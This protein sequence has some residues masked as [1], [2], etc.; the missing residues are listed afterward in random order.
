MAKQRF[1]QAVKKLYR[2]I[3]PGFVT[4][5]S[6][7]DPSGIATYSQTG[8]QFGYTQLWFAI[9]SMPF[10]IA[11]QEMCGR[12]GMVTGKGIAGLMRKHYS[13]PLLWSM[14]SLLFLANVINLGA[15]LGA[16]AAAVQLIWPVNFDLILIVI[17][18]ITLLLLV[19]VPYKIY[20]NILKYLTLSLFA[21]VG[22]ALVVKQDWALVLTSTLIPQVTSQ[23]SYWL[24]L[25]ALLGTTI[26]PY[27]FFW[28]ADQEVEEE[29]SRHKLRTMGQ[30]KPIF[31]I[32]D[33][34]HL[35]VDTTF[36]MIFS[37]LIAFFIIMTTAATLHTQGIVG[38]ASAPQAAAALRPLAG[39]F[40]YLLFSLGIIGAGLLAVPVLAGS[41][42]YAL[43][44]TFHWKE[45][46]YRKFHQAK[47]FYIVMILATLI[48]MLIN[49]AGIEPF[50]LLY[51]TAVFNGVCA[52]PL[53][54]V[55][56]LIANNKKIMGKY[57][58]NFWSNVGGVLITILMTAATGA[59]AWQF[60][61]GN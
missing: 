49:Y 29:V 41:A 13:R 45:G 3:G 14:V 26:S 15:D 40:A 4:G 59:M 7:D 11:V 37:N 47:W 28:Q 1:W 44:E 10:T 58:N 33:I 56:L 38:I 42:A 9:F 27:L 17:T 39:E 54:V 25:V 24:N 20:A 5:A 32:R 43:A 48:G 52:P 12:I 23:S 53:L 36:G 46:L 19:V 6:D 31:N 57:S 51:F 22:A 21:Y 35:R 60:F 30:G 50:K 61:T 8:A 55:I 2:S 34:R 18:G 16:M